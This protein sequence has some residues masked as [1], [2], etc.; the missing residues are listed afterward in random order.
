LHIAVTKTVTV[1]DEKMETKTT[2]TSVSVVSFNAFKVAC[3]LP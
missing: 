1:A 3:W 2:Q